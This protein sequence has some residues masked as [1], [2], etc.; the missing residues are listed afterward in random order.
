MRDI[1]GAEQYA[2][3][4]GAAAYI[5][6]DIDGRKVLLQSIAEEIPADVI[7]DTSRAQQFISSRTGL[8]EAFSN[9]IAI[10]PSGNIIASVNAIKSGDTVNVSER[11]YFRDTV[12]YHE[13]VVSAPFKSKLTGKPVVLMTQPV[14][15]ASGRLR[16]ILAGSLDLSSTR[17]FGQLQALHP[18]KTGYIW[19]L[20]GDG[21]I[22]LHPDTNRI[23][24]RVDREQGGA[25][26]S[27]ANALGGFEGWTQGM[28]KSGV[29]ALLTYRRTR[30]NDWII[31]SVYPV[32][33][34]FEPFDQVRGQAFAT[35]LAVA[36]FAGVMGWLGVARLLR[37][38]SALQR[39]VANL[40]DDSG[41]IEAFNVQRQDEFGNL[42]RAFFE[43]SK[44]RASAEAALEMLA[45]TDP[46][47]G[48][49]NRRMF[50]SAMILA[51]AR[52]ERSKGMLA[53]AYIDIDHFKAI[54]DSLGH[55]AGDLVL[56][57]FARRLRSAVRITDTVVRIA[58]D[59]FTVI[60]ETFTD[61]SD[62]DAL[63]RKIVDAMASPMTIER[64]ELQVGASIGI[65]AGLTES[66][67]MA[68]FI[69]RADA[70]LYRSKQNGRG[71]YFVDM[72][73]TVSRRVVA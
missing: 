47:T 33:E 54:N 28:T 26:E 11:D 30:T 45:M 61:H 21:T 59:E 19:L 31:A 27:T 1:L 69:L 44:K 10:D 5:D 73:D 4:T 68:D 25:T 7:A 32:N 22:I 6:R 2:T 12:S 34:A 52:A 24:R 37:P 56:I 15:D 70:A 65:C 57:E 63:G 55:A 43:V 23:L 51:Y 58:G 20:A 50:D 39:H 17:I 66:I 64:H 36:V 18:G 67:P 41:D 42:S 16:F 13:G 8:R 14:I 53:V 71:C 38:L 46:L 3:L 49:S 62:S 72:T 29:E 48:L 60:F 40:S 35:A 9:V